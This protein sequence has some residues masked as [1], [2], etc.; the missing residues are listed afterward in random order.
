M[1]LGAIKNWGWLIS[2]QIETVKFNHQIF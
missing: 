1:E 2:N